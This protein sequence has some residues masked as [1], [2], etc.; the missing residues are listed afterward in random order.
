MEGCE[1]STD[2]LATARMRWRSAED[3]LY[4]QVMTDPDT[5]QR[6]VSVMAAVLDELRRRAC[7]TEELLELEARPSEVLAAIAV[8]RSAIAGIGD[9]LVLL[10][11]CS[12]RSRELQASRVSNAEGKG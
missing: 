12:L 2:W 9:E 11:G 5:Y 3:R 4:P 7:T 1:P 10:A 8:D 6:V